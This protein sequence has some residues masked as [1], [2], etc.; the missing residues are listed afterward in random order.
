MLDYLLVINGLLLIIVGTSFVVMYFWQALISQA[1]NP[2]ESQVFLYLPIL[3]IGV[4]LFSGG[5]F[6]SIRGIKKIKS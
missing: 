1:G 2:E 3:L 4:A 5:L 6:L